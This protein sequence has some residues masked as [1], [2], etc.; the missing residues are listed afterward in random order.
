M[1]LFYSILWLFVLPLIL[2]RLW[3]RGYKEPNYRQHIGERLGFYW[4]LDKLNIIPP[5]LW[6]HAVSIGEMRAAQ[7]LI[8]ALLKT[9]PQHLILLTHITAAGRTVGQQLLTSYKQRIIQSFFPYDISWICA[10]FLYYFKPRISILIETEV[11]PN[12]I[13]QCVRY[14]VPIIL[15]NARLSERSLHKWQYFQSIVFNT[16]KNINYIAAQSYADAQRLYTLGARNIVVTGSIKFDVK[17]PK[18]M[19]INGQKWRQSFNKRKVLLCASTREGEEQLII[20]MLSKIN[21]RDF[22]TIIVPRHP[23]RFHDVATLIK[24]RGFHMEFRSKMQEKLSEEIDIL[25]GDSIGEMFSYYAA[26]DIAFIGGSLLPL[27]GQN[28]IEACLLGKP[29]LIGQ[30]TFNFHLISENAVKAGAAFRIRNAEMMLF[31]AQMLLNDNNLRI[32]I[33]HNAKK[34]ACCYQGATLNTM[35]LVKSLLI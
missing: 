33:G 11:W 28:L 32:K 12:M 13:K 34:F 29:V 4:Q 27:G 6:I 1:R 15:V 24:R 14:R 5:I 23:R 3:W 35:K 22:L 9:N 8:E 31:M 17:V 20:D 7:P 18:Q 26:C 16:I 21:K 2:L 19:F 10:R 25:L 30:Y